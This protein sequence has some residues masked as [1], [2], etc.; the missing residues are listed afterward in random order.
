MIVGTMTATLRFI[1]VAD[2]FGRFLLV[3]LSGT[4]VNL[5]VLWLLATLGLNHLLAALIATEV[6]ITNNFI[7]HDCWTFKNKATPHQLSF[8]S[9]FWRFQLVSSLTASLT[10]GLFAIF[11]NTW[12]LYY[13]FAQFIAI[14]LAT[15]VNFGINSRITWR[16]PA[17]TELA[18]PR[19][20]LSYAGLTLAE[21]VEE[22]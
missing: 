3:G 2:T 20:D 19:L 17:N 13:L 4:I 18:L 1:K 16:K 11:T 10:L 8:F 12:H 15:L 6:S 9:R 5:G 14:G 22:C 7:W 21:E